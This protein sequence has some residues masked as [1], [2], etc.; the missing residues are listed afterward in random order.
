VAIASHH[1]RRGRANS[2]GTLGSPH[3]ARADPLAANPGL[4]IDIAVT[5]STQDQLAAHTAIEHAT[6][7]SRNTCLHLRLAVPD[8]VLCAR[9]VH[10]VKCPLIRGD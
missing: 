2:S 5:V 8:A 7:D 1:R 10:T 9:P 3:H 4:A 6:T